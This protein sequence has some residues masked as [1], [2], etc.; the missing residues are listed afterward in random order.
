MTDHS[1]DYET[2]LF[3]SKSLTV[4]EEALRAE[5]LE[6]CRA[7]LAKGHRPIPLHAALSI[8]ANEMKDPPADWLRKR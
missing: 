8:A 7:K 1:S 4:E 6:W 2:L 3:G 5:L